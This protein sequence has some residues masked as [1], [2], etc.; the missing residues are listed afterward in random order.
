[1]LSFHMDNLSCVLDIK[2]VDEMTFEEIRELI[3]VIE[4]GNEKINGKIKSGHMKRDDNRLDLV[5]I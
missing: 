4:D 3:G 2:R 5:D 1:M